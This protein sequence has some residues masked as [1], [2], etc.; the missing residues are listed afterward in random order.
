MRT[1][2]TRE[3]RGMADR[4]PYVRGGARSRGRAPMFQG[5]LGLL[6]FWV[7][8]DFFVSYALGEPVF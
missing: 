6:G 3:Q 4:E 7:S 1:M 5:F 2:E 8:F